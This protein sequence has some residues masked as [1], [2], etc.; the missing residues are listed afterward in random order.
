MSDKWKRRFETSASVTCVI[1]ADSTI[2]YCNPAWDDFALRNGGERATTRDVVGRA[3]FD[4]IPSVLE[5]HHRKL[6]ATSRLEI[7]G[8]AT[9]YNCHTID[10]FR[11]YHLKILPI[12]HTDLLAMVHSFRVER[13]LTFESRP[14]SEYHHG[15]GSV[16]T[17]CA[18]CRRVKNNRDC[19]W[20]WVPDFVSAPPQRTSH[21]ICPDCTMYLYA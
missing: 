1:D 5:P 3:L 11:R 16:V 9:D 4:Y 14:V 12:P 21:G 13:P 6:I 7:G 15:P 20:D 2:I 10:K 17:M 19:L 18:Q 8:A